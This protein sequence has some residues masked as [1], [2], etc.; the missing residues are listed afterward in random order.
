MQLTKVVPF[1]RLRTKT[2]ALGGLY[3]KK[4]KFREF[5]LTDGRLITGQNPVAT[6]S[7]AGALAALVT[8]LTELV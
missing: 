6:S 2:R 7:T 1:P 5:S 8:L 4:G 3:E